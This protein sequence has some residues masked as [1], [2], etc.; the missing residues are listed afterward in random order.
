MTIAVLIGIVIAIVVGIN[1]IQPISS[2][3][4]TI[5][6]PTYSSAVSSISGIL[7]IIFAAIIILG[8]V[9]WMGFGM[10]SKKN[11]KE[12]S[13]VSIT[14]KHNGL[15]IINIL[16]NKSSQYEKF[17][18]NLD[19]VLG[20]KTVTYYNNSNEKIPLHLDSNKELYIDDQNYDWYIVDKHPTQ[21]MFKVIGLH[22]GDASKNVV[23]IIGANEIVDNE[24]T[25]KKP[26][27]IQIKNDK[28]K[29]YTDKTC[30]D[31]KAIKQ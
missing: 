22:K 19:D 27:L 30:L 16:I 3:V 29:D 13:Q 18:N 5:T 9:S 15:S 1:L 20:V 26:Y 28:E 21:T 11:K 6:T 2:A 17:I 12:P 7:P 14:V 4:E 24:E 23:Y 10:S 25:I 8:A 31:Y